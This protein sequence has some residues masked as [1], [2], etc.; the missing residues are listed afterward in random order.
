MSV[1]ATVDHA[2]QVDGHEAIE[3]SVVMSSTGRIVASD[4]ILNIVVQDIDPSSAL[5]TSVDHR[6]DSARPPRLPGTLSP[7]LRPGR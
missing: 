2:T 6:L 1:L 3:A 4:I 7:F 5:H